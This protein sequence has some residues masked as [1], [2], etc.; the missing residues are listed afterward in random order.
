LCFNVAQVD[1]FPGTAAVF[2]RGGSLTGNTDR[3][4]LLYLEWQN[5]LQPDIV[6]PIVAK[7]VFVEKPF[8]RPEAK[9]RQ[10]DLLGIVVEEGSTDVVH[11]EVL[12]VDPEP[13][14]VGVGPPHGDL[15]R[16][17]KIRNTATVAD[18]KAA[19]DHGTDTPQHYFELINKGFDHIWHG[20][21]VPRVP[22]L[23]SS[24]GFSRSHGKCA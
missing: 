20:A 17:M 12:A 6:L 24:P 21:I 14:Q 8:P 5:T 18:P 2:R 4:G 23:Y 19:P 11:A 1:E 10:A 13:M 7:I 3:V 16:V 22:N 9:V 15:K